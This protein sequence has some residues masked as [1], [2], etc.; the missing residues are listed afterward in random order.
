[1][2]HFG[3][4]RVALV[5][6]HTGAVMA[7]LF[8]AS[9]P[10]AVAAVVLNGFP[11]LSEEERAHFGTFYFGPKAPQPD[12]SHLLV[13]WQNRLRATPG[14]TD[15]ALMHRYTVQGLLRGETNWKAFPLII[16]ADLSALLGS[17]RPPTLLFTNTGEDL[18]AATRRAYSLRPKFFQ[19]AELEGGTHDII[20]EQPA[21]WLRVVTG[22]LHENRLEA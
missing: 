10:E 2:R 1:M 21:E 15:L 19:Y 12:G 6:H 13:A 5:G 20:D 7:A 17:L 9:N 18:Y 3:W 14:W 22:F 16:Q 4:P 8:A 11:L